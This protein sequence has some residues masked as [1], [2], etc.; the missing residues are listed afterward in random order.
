MSNMP[1]FDIGQR[2]QAMQTDANVR[3]GFA[4]VCG[5]VVGIIRQRGVCQ[6]CR[7]FLEDGRFVTIENSNL[8]H[9]DE[10]LYAR[11]KSSSKLKTI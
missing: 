6:T 3:K 4:N 9:V 2:C 10:E 5:V 7:V 11:W 1:Q 8:I